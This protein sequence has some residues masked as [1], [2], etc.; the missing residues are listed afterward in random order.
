MIKSVCW[1]I[2]SRCNENCKFCYHNARN[3]DLSLEDNR[4]IFK[5]SLDFGPEKISFMGGE[6]LLY[7][8]LFKLIKWG[9]T[10]VRD[11]F[12]FDRIISIL[13]YAQENLLSNGWV[14]R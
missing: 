10:I 13:A 12:H 4:I 8:D 6:P 11:R 5:R 1:D 7:N 3:K 14:R 2:T 9:M